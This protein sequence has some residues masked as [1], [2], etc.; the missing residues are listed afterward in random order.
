[1]WAQ[2]INNSTRNAWPIADVVP[3][4]F[5]ASASAVQ[6]WYRAALSG[7]IA[8]T[9]WGTLAMQSAADCTEIASPAFASG[10][11][12]TQWR[13]LSVGMGYPDDL[14]MEFVPLQVRR[15][16]WRYAVAYAGICLMHILSRMAACARVCGH[17]PNAYP[18][19][20][21]GMRSRLRAY[22]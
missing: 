20:H 16:A 11:P 4:G 12:A 19:T 7:G 22:A 13:C 2:A 1:M 14:V 18:S 8:T 3:V 9:S 21:G 15:R 17:M 5:N 6:A 10:A